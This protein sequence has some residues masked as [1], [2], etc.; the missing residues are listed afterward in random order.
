MCRSRK[1]LLLWRR[2]L[3]TDCMAGRFKFRDFSML[4]LTLRL[5]LLDDCLDEEVL[6]PAWFSQ[7][8]PQ[9]IKVFRWDFQRFHSLESLP[10]TREGLWKRRHPRQKVP[11]FLHRTTCDGMLLWENVLL[12]CAICPHFA[13]VSIFD[14]FCFWLPLLP[15]LHR[16]SWHIRKRFQSSGS[17]IF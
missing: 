8:L 14:I 1:I 10:R 13:T 5:R 11:T 3:R 12:L 16:L 6:R 7:K 4:K 9:G 2:Y 15:S 17:K